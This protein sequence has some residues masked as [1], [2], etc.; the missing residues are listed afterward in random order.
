MNA[1]WHIA[2][3]DIRR[4]VL[5]AGLWICFVVGS[6][7]WFR[8]AAVGLDGGLGWLGAMTSWSRLLVAIQLLFA[9]VLA[10]TVVL[11]DPLIGHRAFWPTRPISGA[12]LLA[13]KVTATLVLFVA[14]PALALMAVWLG[15]GFGFGTAL[16]AAVQFMAKLAMVIV[17]ALMVAGLT[18]NLAQFVF[19]AVALIFVVGFAPAAAGLIGPQDLEMAV[20]RTR[21]NV[22]LGAVL[23]VMAVVVVHQYLTRAARRSWL[24]LAVG[25]VMSVGIAAAWC[26]DWTR[27][28]APAAPLGRDAKLEVAAGVSIERILG[29]LETPIPTPL[30]R[31]QRVPTLDLRARANGDRIHVPL[32]GRGELMWSDGTRVDVK[33]V[34]AGA[35]PD[36]A[37]RAALHAG[38]PAA[39]FTW[40]MRMRRTS[41][42]EVVLRREPAEWHGWIE[43]GEFRPTTRLELPLL[44]DASAE[45]GPNRIRLLTVEKPAGDRPGWIVL[46]DRDAWPGWRYGPGANVVMGLRREV[47]D[48]F[49]LVARDRSAVHVLHEQEVGAVSMAA[50]VTGILRLGLPADIAT[51]WEGATLVKVR[52]ERVGGSR[53]PVIARGVTIVPDK[54]P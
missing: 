30:Q 25:L 44:V 49:G 21:M 29:S 50:M 38:V 39:S 7:L 48:R 3:K 33:L 27:E 13:A 28:P 18:R 17:L 19:C 37:V 8:L 41:E 5:P 20:L 52:F 11:E 6:V 43:V 45:S 35:I 53:R 12:R 24:L 1:V 2:A 31:K 26:W 36:A 10:G 34:G 9:L 32:G 46:E 15:I 54:E 40:S 23:S 16:V 14:A 4:M 22:L 47:R 51:E 42:P